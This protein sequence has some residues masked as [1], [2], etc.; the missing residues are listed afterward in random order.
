MTSYRRKAHNHIMVLLVRFVLFVLLVQTKKL[1]NPIQLTKLTILIQAINPIKIEAIS[2]TEK[3]FEVKP[4]ARRAY[5]P[6]G[7][8]P[9]RNRR[10][11]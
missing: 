1:I 11:M 7:T 9:D 6:E 8:A 2:K 4:P 3:W 10:N 5:A